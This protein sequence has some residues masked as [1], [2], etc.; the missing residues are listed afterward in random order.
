MLPLSNATTLDI[1]DIKGSFNDDEAITIIRELGAVRN[2][3]SI[4]KIDRR[5]L[6]DARKITG[7]SLSADIILEDSH[8]LSGRFALTRTLSI[9]DANR[10]AEIYGGGTL[11]LTELKIDDEIFMIAPKQSADSVD[12]DIV[13]K[14]VVER[15]TRDNRFTIKNLK[16]LEDGVDV[17]FDFSDD[18]NNAIFNDIELT[19]IT[20]KKSFL[21]EP[22]QTPLLANLPNNRINKVVGVNYQYITIHTLKNVTKNSGSDTTIQADGF[23][24]ALKEA[25]L[26]RTG[27]RGTEE[28]DI[29]VQTDNITAHIDESIDVENGDKIQLTFPEKTAANSATDTKKSLDIGHSVIDG[30]TTNKP[31]GKNY[32]DQEFLLDDKDILEI[33][34]IYDYDTTI[35]NGTNDIESFYTKNLTKKIYFH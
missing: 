19:S 9:N 16:R 23:T 35:T 29:E 27:I 6:S 11:F 12:V 21:H 25:I 22:S 2:D 26:Y 18:D 31:Y 30:D 5:N 3:S 15:I 4:T 7:T 10:D 34:G 17:N 28:I 20:V 32:A 13:Y 24:G 33:T 1:T 8:N 14:A